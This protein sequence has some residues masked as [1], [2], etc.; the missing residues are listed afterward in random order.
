MHAELHKRFEA[1]DARLPTF[2]CVIELPVTHSGARSGES[3]ASGEANGLSRRGR[4]GEAS[5]DGDVCVAAPHQGAAAI[6]LQVVARSRRSFQLHTL[7]QQ[8]KSVNVESRELLLEGPECG[9]VTQF[10][11]GAV[12]LRFLEFGLLFM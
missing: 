4:G 2:F 10:R 7:R 1:G 3:S 9:V 6:D 12:R 8:R 11:R 5:S